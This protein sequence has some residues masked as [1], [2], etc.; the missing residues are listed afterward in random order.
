MAFSSIRPALDSHLRVTC[1]VVRLMAELI[2][3]MGDADGA[4]GTKLSAITPAA[5]VTVPNSSVVVVFRVVTRTAAWVAP[6]GAF[7]GAEVKFSK[8]DPVPPKIVP[9]N[10]LPREESD[11]AVVAGAIV[12]P[13][14]K[15]I[16]PQVVLVIVTH[17][18]GK[19][20]V[21]SRPPSLGGGDLILLFHA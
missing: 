20:V 2:S 6:G 17:R 14:D 16:G 21:H 12:N 15:D 5:S 11:E 4:A 1:D 8:A 9:A 7:C 3:L 18:I 19:N 10:R 13:I